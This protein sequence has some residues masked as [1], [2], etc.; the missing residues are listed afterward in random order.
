MDVG[1]NDGSDYAVPAA[2]KNA[3]TVV[4]FDPMR[5]NVEALRRNVVP[6]ALF[7]VCSLRWCYGKLRHVVSRKRRG[8]V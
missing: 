5:A 2:S 8:C 6:P 1:S 7:R 4:A 3:H